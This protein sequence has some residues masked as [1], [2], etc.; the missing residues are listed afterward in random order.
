[1]RIS[2]SNSDGAFSVAADQPVLDGALQSGLNL[3]HSCRGGNCGACRARLLAGTVSYPHGLP[4]GLSTAE[5]AEGFILLCQ[6]RAQTDLTL[7]IIELRA[8]RTAV[9]K[10]L[11]ARVERIESLTHDVL[12]LLLRLPAVECF[13]FAPGQYVDVLLSGGRRRSFSIASPPHDSR[14]LELH[15]RRVLG[16]EFTEP[17]FANQCRGSL[18]SLEGPLGRFVYSHNS[19]APM[20]LVAG[21]TGLAPLKSI[22]RHVLENALPR[23]MLLYWGVRSQRDLYD[24]ALLE[25]FARAANF[26]YR[27]VLSEPDR[28]WHGAQGWVHEAVLREMN[29]LQGYDIY[30]SG[31]PSM[32]SAIRDAFPRHGA[33][34]N[35]LYFDSFDYAQDSLERHRKIAATK[36]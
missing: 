25:E 10:R 31:P 1:M 24:Q 27:T 13:D 20:L 35:H 21:G 30:A 7:E 36:A 11:P 33:D 32:V 26:R 19:Q 34:L 3:P 5:L 17:L 6:A 4:L 29:S 18:L 15:V 14:L 16:G 12:R 23:Q 28:D 9:I 22:I 2:L 8:A